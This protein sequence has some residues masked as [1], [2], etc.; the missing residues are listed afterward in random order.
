[1]NPTNGNNI[2]SSHLVNFLKIISL[3]GVLHLSQLFRTRPSR[4]SQL[5]K[6]ATAFMAFDQIWDMFARNILKHPSD[7]PTQQKV[8]TFHYWEVSPPLTTGFSDAIHSIQDS[9]LQGYDVTRVIQVEVELIA[10]WRGQRH[11]RAWS[12]PWGWTKKIRG[13]LHWFVDESCL[14][15]II[16]GNGNGCFECFGYFVRL[17]FSREA[18]SHTIEASYLHWVLHSRVFRFTFTL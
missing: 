2:K 1:M 17:L 16:N 12:L 11:P 9:D 6:D 15:V 8:D 5:P 7:H 10:C 14:M 18:F 13:Y 3:N 4:H